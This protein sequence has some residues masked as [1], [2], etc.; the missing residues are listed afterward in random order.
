M[1]HVWT[2]CKLKSLTVYLSSHNFTLRLVECMTASNCKCLLLCDFVILTKQLKHT[3][4]NYRPRIE[5]SDTQSIT[6]NDLIRLYIHIAMEHGLRCL[7][8]FL[9]PSSIIS[10]RFVSILN[11]GFCK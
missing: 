9:L 6:K 4:I 5:F 11:H 10:V 7:C 8:F 3:H 1:Q 2:K